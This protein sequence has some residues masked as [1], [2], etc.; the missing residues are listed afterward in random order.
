[1]VQ[2]EQNSAFNHPIEALEKGDPNIAN[3]K[4]RHHPQ[5]YFEQYCST[6]PD[7]DE[8]KVYDN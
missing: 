2:E 1:M 5:T 4:N 6:H 3:R 7:A 8:C